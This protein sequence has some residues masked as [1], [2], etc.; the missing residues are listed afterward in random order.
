[1]TSYPELEVRHTDRKSDLDCGWT[2]NQALKSSLLENPLTVF[3]YCLHVMRGNLRKILPPTMLATV[4]EVGE[5]TTEVGGATADVGG[6]VVDGGGI[7]DKV[8]GV[9]DDNEEEEEGLE[10]EEE[11]I[12]EDNAITIEQISDW[13]TVNLRRICC[14]LNT[15]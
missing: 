12:V 9:D 8:G 2:E 7:K 5:S 1:M 4:V 6:D 11:E 3:M 15:F 10:E 14:R 13:L